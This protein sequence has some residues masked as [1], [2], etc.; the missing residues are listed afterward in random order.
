ERFGS[1]NPLPRHWRMDRNDGWP[2]L[3]EAG[4]A[5]GRRIPPGL[6]IDGGRRLGYVPLQAAALVHRLRLQGRLGDG[7]TR[8]KTDRVDF[9]PPPQVQKIT[10]TQLLPS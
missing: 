10:A 8:S 6:R 3:R 9:E 1:G 4:Y 5:T 2:N 7:R